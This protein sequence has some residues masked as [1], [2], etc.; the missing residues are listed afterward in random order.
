MTDP[1]CHRLDHLRHAVSSRLAGW[2]IV[3]DGDTV[4]FT[5]GQPTP[6]SATVSKSSA[7][8]SGREIRAEVGLRRVGDDGSF[9]DSSS[10]K[11]LRLTISS[12]TVPSTGTGRS[13][14][15]GL[16]VDE[17][18]AWRNHLLPQFDE[19]YLLEDPEQA[20]ARMSPVWYF[21]I[22]LRGSGGPPIAA[23]QDFDW[24]AHR[25]RYRG[26]RVSLIDRDGTRVRTIYENPRFPAYYLPYTE[27]RGTYWDIQVREPPAHAGIG[28]GFGALSKAIARR[29]AL[30]ADFRPLAL[31]WQEARTAELLLR[32]ESTQS[33]YRMEL[34]I[35]G[36]DD[37][38]SGTYLLP[39]GLGDPP[40]RL[41]SPVQYAA[42]ELA[43][44]RGY[45]RSGMELWGHSSPCP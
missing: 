27:S 30:G 28:R 5:D 13:L 9:P 31:N 33:C 3:T 1:T 15:G 2:R 8:D 25:V 39:G 4:G 12:T 37:L 23:P 10:I 14:V 24:A 11:M 18:T 44:L 17:A 26:L 40:A 35:P 19:C 34:T 29:A 20:N 45:G 22:L 32:D 7:I 36:D 6:V 43:R 21:A 16:R 42:G 41:V 38:D